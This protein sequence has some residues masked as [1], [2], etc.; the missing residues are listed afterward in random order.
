MSRQRHIICAMGGFLVAAASAFFALPAGAH[1]F[2]VDIVFAQTT[3]AAARDGFLREFRRASDERDSHGDEESDGHLGGLDVYS[4]VVVLGGDSPDSSG[5]FIVVAGGDAGCGAVAAG[6]SVIVIDAALL[7]GMADAAPFR[8]DYE[9]RYGALPDPLEL[10]GYLV[11]RQI[12]AMVRPL[13]GA[14]DTAALRQDLPGLC[15]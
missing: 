2:D 1:S 8:A 5:V 12:D 14:D 4:N 9:S 11:A 7:A 10:S 13:G 15:N 6:P 3:P